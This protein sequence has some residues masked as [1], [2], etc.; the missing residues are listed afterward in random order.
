[1]DDFGLASA[2]T[3]QL[4]RR[5]VDRGVDPG[6]TADAFL[7]EALALFAA[8]SGM[9][10]TARGLASAWARLREATDNG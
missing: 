5:L 4:A 3:H 8:H 9:P 2:R 1:M 6:I 7:A 10:E